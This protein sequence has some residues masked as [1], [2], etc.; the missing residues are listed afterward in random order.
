MPHF[1]FRCC[2]ASLW[3]VVGLFSI[4]LYHFRGFLVCHVSYWQIWRTLMWM[5][6]LV[7]CCWSCVL[8]SSVP[9]HFNLQFPYKKTWYNLRIHTDWFFLH[10][11]GGNMWKLYQKLIQCLGVVLA[12]G[13]RLEPSDT[14]SVLVHEAAI[15]R[16]GRLASCRAF[17]VTD[18]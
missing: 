5:L 10:P 4:Y 17:V 1:I 15:P 14:R 6:F 12:S 11:H 8:Y 18:Y 13:S 3:C 2:I 9:S 16:V 7:D